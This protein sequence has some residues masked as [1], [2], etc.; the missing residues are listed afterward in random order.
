MF[1]TVLVANRGEIAVRIIL[2]LR[3]LGV[4][5][6]AIYSDEDEGARHVGEADEA[7]WVG[8]RAAH[9]SYLNIERI[10]E[11]LARS[12][13]QAVHPGYG[14]L[15]ENAD[16]VRAC[17]GAGIIFIGPSAESVEM[18]G[19]KIR[20]KEAVA[21]AG[22]AVVPGRAQ[23]A[24]DDADLAAA[25]QE[26]GYPVLVKPSAGGGGKGMRLV[27]SP[28]EL[29]SAVISAR[30]ESTASFGDDTLFIERYVQSPRHLEVQI[31]FDQ[32]GDA[33]H[34]GERECS[35]QRRHQKVIEEA[36]SPMMSEESRRALCDAALRVGEVAHYRGVGTVEF[37]VSSL[38][39]EEFFFM[40]MNTR[41]Q[42]EH[43]VTEMVT[44]VDLVEQQ[45][46]VAAG[47]HLTMRQD[48][49]RIEGHA[50]EARVYAEDPSRDFL[51]TGGTLLLLRE[52]RIPGVR[53]DSSLMPGTV[54]GTTYDPMLAKVIA[55]GEDRE[56]ALARLDGA[57]EKMITLGVVTNTTFLR[58]LL[59]SEE[60]RVGA[61]DTNLIG[62]LLESPQNESRDDTGVRECATGYSL[63]H[64]LR[65]EG[66]TPRPSRFDVRDG[67]RVAGNAPTR[68]SLTNA[69]G[70]VVTFEITGSAREARIMFDS[71]D[72]PLL[73]RCVQWRELSKNVME[74][75]VAV[76]GRKVQMF[77]AID[78][79][80][81]WIFQQGVTS[82]WRSVPKTRRDE[83][84]SEHDGKILSPMPGVV[85]QVAVTEGDLVAKG[86]VLI[87][88]EAM[89]MEYQLR[90]LRSGVV[91][92]INVRSGDQV[93][94]DQIVAHVRDDTPSG[95]LDRS[96]AESI[97]PDA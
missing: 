67:W 48:D 79:P 14:F 74:L 62:R 5:S 20:A 78:G 27:Q 97:R 59:S 58:R 64:L 61:L 68:F 76:A 66:R 24:M 51:P 63:A 42:V 46:R 92:D 45:V 88:V 39:P 33:V 80:L 50:I 91:V 54:V 89:K 22:V 73:V 52:P 8:S 7:L 43:P 56:L 32:Y 38:R 96:H 47:E 44:G 10:L 82:R 23:P 53:V 19:D 11:A 31:L 26:V 17:E 25:A 86:D 16:F 65:A 18:M 93:V 35:L 1:D 75:F 6:V 3:R 36:P 13:A 2:T 94:L 84:N 49:V 90:A 83:G 57:L 34:L 70:V 60:V 72:T 12:G 85:I 41:L 21:R 40:E 4:R 30:R 77:V 9:D 69:E 95:Q 28:E 81:T 29:Q 15:S 37:I 55:H 87:V 71:S